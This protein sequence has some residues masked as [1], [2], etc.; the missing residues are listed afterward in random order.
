[1]HSNRRSEAKSVFEKWFAGSTGDSPVPSGDWRDGAG[2]TIRANRHGLFATL[3]APVP[4]GGSPTGAGGS[5]A[6]PIFNTGSKGLNSRKI[7]P[8]R[9]VAY[10]LRPEGVNH[11]R[12]KIRLLPVVQVEPMEALRCECRITDS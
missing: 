1:M 8:V 2:S 4:V 6:P 11:E 10:M 5:P 9:S 7:A 12:I 3:L